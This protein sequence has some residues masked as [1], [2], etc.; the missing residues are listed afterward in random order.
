MPSVFMYGQVDPPALQSK[1]VTIGDVFEAVGSH[2]TGAMS[3]EELHELE[4]VAC[5]SAGSCGG[6]HPPNTM[7]CLR[8]IGLALPGSPRVRRF[9]RCLC[10]SLGAEVMG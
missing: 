4:C 10:R 8:A 6:L 7:A 2:S 3:D 1:A 5:P 9:A